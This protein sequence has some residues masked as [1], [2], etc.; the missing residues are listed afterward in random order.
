M[1]PTSGSTIRADL[2]AVVEQ[3]DANIERL[4]GALVMPP[5]P[6]DAKSGTYPKLTIAKG[7]LMD[8]VATE[9]G[10]LASYGRISR[11]WEA[12]TYD[13]VD[14]GLEEG[15]DDTDQRD[16]KRFFDLESTAAR[17]TGNNVKLSHEKRV[18]AAIFNTGNFGAATNSAVAYTDA[19]LA[20]INFPKDVLAAIERIS[21]N[22]R[23]ANTIVLSS[24]VLTR[25]RL[26]TLLQQWVRG[27]VVGESQ[28]PVTAASIAASFADHGI[29]Q[30]LVGEARE[31][32]G[33]KGAAFTSA[34]IWSNDYVWVGACNPKAATPK[35][36]G[37]GF[38]LYWNLEGGLFVTETYRDEKHRANMVRVRQNTAEK[39]VDETAGTLI[40]TQYA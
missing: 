3:A 13:C 14:R 1:Y 23:R 16:L 39:V 38:T 36:G 27:S 19:N 15:V 2:N 18:A 28:V 31:N 11:S 32:T 21:D 35:D 30:V 10:R 33:K 9:R 4:I 12:D 37:A 8:A 29:E 40:A 34:P 17:L 25:I 22:G 26:S 24:K 6:V 20:T 5:M 7:A